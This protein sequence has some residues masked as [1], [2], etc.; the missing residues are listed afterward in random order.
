MLGKNSLARSEIE[1]RIIEYKVRDNPQ[2][3]IASGG[4][5]K[6]LTQWRFTD[7]WL[8]YLSKRFLSQLVWNILLVFSSRDFH[9][10]SSF[11]VWKHKDSKNKLSHS[12]KFSPAAGFLFCSCTLYSIRS[13][14]THIHELLVWLEKNSLGDGR[15][16][17]NFELP[18][19]LSLVSHIQCGLQLP[20]FQIFIRWTPQTHQGVYYDVKQFGFLK[21]EIW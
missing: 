21:C 13:I 1:Y 11:L 5:M 4:L 6:I 16:K 9:L 2:K 20:F 7:W 15:Q 8:C 14:T 10:S 3:K 17:I 19:V 12:K 18:Y